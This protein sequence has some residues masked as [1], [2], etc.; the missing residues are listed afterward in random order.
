MSADKFFLKSKT[1]WGVI[2][3][4]LPALLPVLGISLGADDTALITATGDQVMTAIGGL[5]AVY[6]RFKA[7]GVTVGVE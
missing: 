7:G 2:V 1:I 3:M 5:I 6:G 4:A